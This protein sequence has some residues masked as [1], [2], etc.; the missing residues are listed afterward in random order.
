[1]TL[2]EAFFRFPTLRTSRLRL[3]MPVSGDAKALYQLYGNP[4]VTRYLDWDGPASE[5]EAE[6]VLAY[7]GQQYHTG[8]VLRWAVTSPEADEMLGTVMLG[9]FQKEAIAD[10]GYDLTHSAWRQGYMN[11]TLTEV[12]RF[13]TAD[14]KLVRIQAYVSPENI[15]S[16]KL[17]E[18]LGFAKE[19][20]LRKAGYHETRKFFYDVQLFALC[21]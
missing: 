15:A 19:G 16:A 18:K 2:Q 20:L 9:N 13:A 6:A 14:L 12:L 4:L 7:Y 11:E 3:R 10:L 5:E 8:K 21:P 1:M 17:L